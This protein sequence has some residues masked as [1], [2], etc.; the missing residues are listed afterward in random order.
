M[1]I[2]WI[3]A[4]NGSGSNHWGARDG[5]HYLKEQLNGSDLLHLTRMPIVEEAATGRA[6]KAL[7]ALLDFNRRLAQRTAGAHRSGDFPV[8]V[9][10][11]HSCAI[12]TW[13]GIHAALRQ[14]LGM[15]WI[16]AH[17]DAHTFETSE[18]GNIHGM[19]LATLLGHGFAPFTDLL[20]EGPK[21]DPARTVLFG[22]RS[23]ERGEAR[24]LEELRVRVYMT[25]EIFDR[26]FAAC[27]REAGDRVRGGGGLPFGISLD[28]DALDPRQVPSVGT[29]VKRGLDA[30]ELLR[31]LPQILGDEELQAFELVE[32]NPHEDRGDRGLSF[33]IEVLNLVQ[34]ARIDLSVAP[35]RPRPPRPQARPALRP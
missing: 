18:T 26:G 21:L 15:L 34:N 11:D 8:V 3:G 17:M 7:P 32:F 19:P 16:D 12:G 20:E 4:A 33:V 9:G 1:D 5:A 35:L 13:A 10:G 31:A 30:G 23:F 6:L 14:P 25:D 28:L 27:F 22:V 2:A 29:P 24:L